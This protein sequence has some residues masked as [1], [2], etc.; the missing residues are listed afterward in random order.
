MLTAKDFLSVLV[1]LLAS[2]AT[3]G[4]RETNGDRFKRGLPPL[5]PTNVFDPNKRHALAPRWSAVP[6]SFIAGKIALY[7][8]PD[9]LGSPLCHLVATT[10]YCNYD[11]D[12][13]HDTFGLF[14]YPIGTKAT[15]TIAIRSID[16]GPGAYLQL[17]LSGD[18]SPTAEYPEIVWE[19]FAINTRN[20]PAGSPPEGPRKFDSF[21]NTVFHIDPHTHNITANFVKPDTTAPDSYF[22]VTLPD[23][24]NPLQTGSTITITD[25]V[26]DY[27]VISDRGSNSI[28]GYLK[29]ERHHRFN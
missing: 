13:P 5:K 3:A 25:D 1:V 17:L 21:E 12:F 20:T 8:S 2:L 9:F 19:T 7:K 11:A 16:D 15:D 18:N 24:S 26:K 6:S 10:A 28:Q 22:I 23:P 4:S 27:L 14:A 29:F